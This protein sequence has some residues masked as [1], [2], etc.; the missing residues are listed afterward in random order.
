M[1]GIAGIERPRATKEVRSMLKRLQHR[2]TDGIEV[3]EKGNATFGVVWSASEEKLVHKM[4]KQGY[5]TDTS[6]NGHFA[7]VEMKNGSLTLLRDKIGVVPLYY[8]KTTDGELC[9][10]SEIKALIPITSEINELGPASFFDGDKIKDYGSIEAKAPL[11]W[12]VEEITMELRDTLVDAVK[13]SVREKKKIGVW[14][15]GG[16]NSSI[17]SAVASRYVDDVQTFSIGF[18]GSGNLK[19]AQR[20]ANHIDSSHHEIIVTRDDLVEAIPRAIYHLESFDAL[21]VRKG[22]MNF[23]ISR[24]AEKKVKYLLLGDGADELFGG[25]KH[26]KS[27][28]HEAI[29]NELV[30]Q[31]GKL[32]NTT[33]QRVD[34]CTAAY[35]LTPLLP[36]LTPKVVKLALRIPARYKVYKGKSKWVLREAM[37]DFLP[38]EI[39]MQ[40]ISDTVVDEVGNTIADL[41]ENSISDKAFKKEQMLPNGWRLST[42]E[43]L[44]YYRIFVEHFGELDNFSWMGRTL[45]NPEV[46]SRD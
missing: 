31:T 19:T 11:D 34:R 35:G 30:E 44:L 21:L 1:T 29:A 3:F 16:M 2:G 24:T 26:I 32:H 25:Y 27:M 8:G 45:N 15:Y 39:L 37:R 20:V 23:I 18:Q 46:R 40:T 38:D 12:G 6:T 13:M 36:F 41:A 43:E 5:I 22:L 42:K 17:I 9:F 33:L 10:A 4:R 7:R 14:L 28:N